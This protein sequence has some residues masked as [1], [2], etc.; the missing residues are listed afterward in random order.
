MDNFL[1]L[2]LIS[3]LCV[4]YIALIIVYLKE[5]KPKVFYKYPKLE[6]VVI[7]MFV[8]IPF[9]AKILI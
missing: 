9:I 5:P 3:F 7:F 4:Y 1:L 6:Y 2:G 8:F